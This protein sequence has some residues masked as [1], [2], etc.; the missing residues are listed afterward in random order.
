MLISRI[1]YYLLLLFFFLLPW[2]TRYIW[3]YGELNGQFW[4]Y[5]TV[6]LYATEILFWIILLLFLLEKFWSKEARRDFFARAKNRKRALLYLIIFLAILGI[7]VLKSFDKG[8]SFYFVFKLLEAM[9]L[10]VVVAFTPPSPPLI[11]EVSERRKMKFFFRANKQIRSIK[12]GALGA[13]WLGGVG[14]AILGLYQFCVQG[15]F[16][17]KWLG[18]AGHASYDVGA[19]VIE[20]AG[21]R[22]LRPYGSLGGPNPF[23]I[24][25]AVIFVLGL[26]LYSRIEKGGRKILFSIG[27]TFVLSGLILS[28]SRGA[29]IAA[30][31]G[32]VFWLVVLFRPGPEGAR[33]RI[34]SL[35][36]KQITYSLLVIF[37]FVIILWPVFATRIRANTRL[38]TRSIS[39]RQN[40]YE[41]AFAFIK[42]Y[43][44]FGVGP[45]FYP[46]RLAAATH[47][48]YSLPVHNTYVLVFAELGLFG[49]II[50]YLIHRKLCQFVSANNRVF[51]PVLATLLAAALFEHFLWSL[52]VGQVF[53]W[54]VWGLVVGRRRS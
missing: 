26:V 28:F 50:F 45:G 51:I 48:L 27:Q 16:A 35:I 37:A 23:G 36:F 49:F 42:K 2:Q 43:P 24:Y 3:K 25:L 44:L 14:Q 31:V 8:I 4:E 38:E 13:L 54:G 46:I 6:S 7:G 19:G 47:S 39:E 17:S 52:Y 32:M 11:C 22:L 21:A 18:I 34:P 30:A 9:A 15:V 29:W 33:G 12:G 53:W 1:R 40:Q 5:G 41:Y 10:G 20:F